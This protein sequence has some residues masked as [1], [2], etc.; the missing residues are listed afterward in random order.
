MKQYKDLSGTRYGRWTVLYEGTPVIREGNRRIRKWVCRCDCG[1]ER[2]VFEKSLKSGASESCG[3]YHSE[4]MHEVGKV[5]TTH[6]M[7]NTRLYRIYKHMRRRCSDPKDI[8]Y[9]RYGGR[10]IRV[11]DEWSTFEP[12]AEWALS[13]GYDDSLSIDRID[14]NGDYTP[15]N[16][17]W[18]T[19]SE[20][21]VNRS[22]TCLI[23]YNGKTQSISQWA[24]EI[25]MPYKKLWKRIH[26]GWTPERAFNS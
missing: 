6:G 5:N 14:T 11:C 22:T 4:L 9:E 3:C 20:Q 16:C 25:G 18:S 26:S 23:E 24:D 19:N 17:K 13:N 7:T 21:A 12:F 1:T 2:E 10:G 8:R 15:D